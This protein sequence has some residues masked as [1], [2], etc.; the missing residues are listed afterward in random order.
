[1]KETQR[2][3]ENSVQ[4]TG[5]EDVEVSLPY[6]FGEPLRDEPWTMSHNRGV[7]VCRSEYGRP[8]YD[9]FHQG[10]PDAATSSTNAHISKVSIPTCR[11]GE[12]WLGGDRI[13]ERLL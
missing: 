9:W 8:L 3:M 12:G 11:C 7:T 4:F 1:M 5:F 6:T 13:K 2:L 10:S